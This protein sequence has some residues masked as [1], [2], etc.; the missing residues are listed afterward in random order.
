MSQRSAERKRLRFVSDRMLG[1]LTRYLRF[2]GYDTLSANS[3]AEGNRRE[4]TILLEIASRDGRVLLTRDRD[5]AGRGRE[6][7]AVL[8]ES[9]DV[10]EQVRQLSG[11]GLIEPELRMTRC[12]LCNALL[13]RATRRE[14]HEADYAPRQ[15][16]DLEFFW[17]PRCRRLYWMGSHGRSL[18][19]RIEAGVQGCDEPGSAPERRPP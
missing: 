10:L 18:Q 7:G 15:F 9:E 4:D 17:C 5:L 8:V 16:P 11:I 14:V 12:S 6:G 1:S 3:L 2:M 13:R 19:K